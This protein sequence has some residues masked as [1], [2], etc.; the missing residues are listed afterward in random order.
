MDLRKVISGSPVMIVAS[1]P[2]ARAIAK[3]SLAGILQK[4][5]DKRR[6]RL[7]LNP[8]GHRP[9]VNDL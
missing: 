3:E 9:G 7:L 4:M 8:G 1:S 2:W 6:R 5:A